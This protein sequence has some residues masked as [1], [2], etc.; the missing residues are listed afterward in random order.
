[1]SRCNQ[2]ELWDELC[3]S[4][5]LIWNKAV[6]NIFFLMTFDVLLVK[7]SY[8]YDKCRND[9]FDNAWR[10]REREHR[11]NPMKWN[12]TEKV[13]VNVFDTKKITVMHFLV[14]YLFFWLKEMT[15]PICWTISL[16]ILQL[17]QQCIRFSL[18]ISTIDSKSV[19]NSKSVQIVLSIEKS[20]WHF[21]CYWSQKQNY[22]LF[23][24]ILIS[25]FQIEIAFR[26]FENQY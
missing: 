13:P 6:N 26:I 21:I 14:R 22:F 7:V 1:M 23:Y 18:T 3:I 16:H 8:D 25:S 20:L 4:I 12:S 17:G 2:R 10:E 24:Q 19:L 9:L 15:I 5:R 11:F